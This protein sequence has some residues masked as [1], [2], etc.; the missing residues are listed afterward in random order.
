MCVNHFVGET[1]FT[2]KSKEYNLMNVSY[3][4]KPYNNLVIKLL[5]QSA[6]AENTNIVSVVKQVVSIGIDDRNN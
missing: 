2:F 3:K 5:L 1:W 6:S 4:H